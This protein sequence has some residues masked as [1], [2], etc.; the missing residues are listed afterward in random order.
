[1]YAAPRQLVTECT[2]IL[3]QE[4]PRATWSAVRGLVTLSV[5]KDNPKPLECYKVDV[6]LEAVAFASPGGGKE[7]LLERLELK[8]V[9][10]GSVAP[11]PC[12]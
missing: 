1:M 12:R 3:P 5:S 11:L 6:T 7:S 10:V 4:R 9:T 8:G 2:D